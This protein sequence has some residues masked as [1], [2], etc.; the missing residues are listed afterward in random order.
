MLN[1]QSRTTNALELIDGSI[2]EY[3][4]LIDSALKPSE[5]NPARYNTTTSPSYQNQCPCLQGSFTTVDIGCADPYVVLLEKS[6]I[7]PTVE[8][9][10]AADVK[11]TC[12]SETPDVNPQVYFVG[13]KRSLDVAYRYDILYNGREITS[14][15]YNGEESFVIQSI[16]K[17]DVRE[18]RPNQLTSYKNAS[19]FN[20]DVCGTYFLLANAEAG[21][22]THIVIPVK[23]TLADFPLFAQ[24]C[25]LQGWMGNWSIRLF[26]DSRNLVTCQVDPAYTIGRKSVTTGSDSYTHEFVQI[27]DTFK[28]ITNY[29][30]NTI[31]PSDVKFTVTNYQFRSCEINLTTQMMYRP[32]YD[33]IMAK[34]M[35]KPLQIPF[36]K[37]VFGRFSQAMKNTQMNSVFSGVIK[38]CESM[39]LI[40]FVDD[41]HHT[42]CK[43]P[44][45]RQLY[46][47][48]GSYGNYPQNPVDTI[49]N[50][51]NP[52]SYVR[53]V[54]MTND[55]LGLEY[56]P[57]ISMNESLS[58]SIH[59]ACVPYIVNN[60]GKLDNTKA[61]TVKT[62]A[63]DFLVG[64]PFADEADFQG[65]LTTQG[66]VN[67]TVY[68]SGAEFK[69][70]E[71]TGT[72]GKAKFDESKLAIGP[73]AMFMCDHVVMIRP[74]PNGAPAEVVV[75]TD[76]I[77]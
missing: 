32:I 3:Y 33:Q 38:C 17:D 66:N 58:N 10:I 77:R 52:A 39:F 44:G 67:I 22:S 27:G 14:Q 4:E 31:T 71:G 37:F 8:F 69:G 47:N 74:S 62:D 21:S 75:C 73:T 46:A 53:F 56:S 12:T 24:F 59:G 55:A 48:I 1:P 40:P 7:T 5:V 49:P 68:S 65:G 2:T 28:G 25:Y 18:K 54:N 35:S 23:I 9:D 63:T 13:W 6:F 42:V 19:S 61:L 72:D 15:T 51:D 36:L 50:G 64:F 11:H 16:M 60:A 70:P 26:P 29:T 20:R 34:Y 76:K 45:F 43:N 57:I 30:S 41:N